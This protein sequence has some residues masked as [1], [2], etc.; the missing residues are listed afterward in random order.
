MSKRKKK[1][2]N[3]SYKYLICPIRKAGI[4]E[5]NYKDVEF[6]KQFLTEN[7]KILPRRVSNVCA[8]NQRLLAVAI[9]KARLLSLLAFVGENVPR[10]DYSTEAVS[11]TVTQEQTTPVD[12]DITSKMEQSEVQP[13]QKD[14][15]N[16]DQVIA[17]DEKATSLETDNDDKSE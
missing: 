17:S 13:H 4:K 11:K 1:H 14:E 10:D 9:K 8:K 15:N 5:I 2:H 16:I 7:G 12:E 6:L 3:Y